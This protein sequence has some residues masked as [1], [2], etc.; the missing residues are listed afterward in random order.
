MA[1]ALNGNVELEYRIDGP[2]AADLIVLSTGFGDQLTF[3]PRPLVDPLIS[4]G[5]R[6]ARFDTRDA[7]LSSDGGCYDLDDLA[8]DL[9]NVIGA[10]GARRSHVI[11]Y[12]MGGQI[13]LRAVLLAPEKIASMALVFSTS[14]AS[15]LSPPRTDALAASASVCERQPL[16][17]AIASRLELIRATSGPAFP[18]DEQQS[19]RM[20][21]EDLARAYRPEGA[22]RHLQAL[23]GS[24]PIHDRLG[25]VRAPAL[26]C[27]A[28]DDCFFAVDHGEDLARRL[29][30][31]LTIMQGAGHNLCPG[32]GAA[33][34]TVLTPFFI[35]QRDQMHA[36]NRR[37]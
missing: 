22:A 30:A 28:S 37:P 5:F 26:I 31:N 10:A 8:L 23:L 17:Q 34:A 2:P 33:L 24:E 4:A 1:R 21:E 13:A 35:Q 16:Q 18:C 7:G 25:D 27:Q 14:G 15:Q 6:V 19:R 12:S 20:V 36:E 32:T 3:W 29:G 9:L 11:G